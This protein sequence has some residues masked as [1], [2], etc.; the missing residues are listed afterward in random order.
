MLKVIVDSLD[1]VPESI[2]DEYVER[3][4]K[5]VLQLD[6]AFSTL[7]RDALQTALGK[8]RQETK[9][10]R[11]QLRKFGDLTPDS[12]E[13]LRAQ[14]EQLQLQL[15]TVNA[16]SDEERNKKIEELVERRAAA[17]VRPLERKLEQ[18]GGELQEIAGERDNLRRERTQNAVIGA[19]TDPALLKE[20]G[21]VPDA[22]EDIRVWATMNFEIEE[23]TDR[24]VSRDTLGTPGLAP[25]DVYADMRTQGQR[26]HWFGST[27][28]AGAS[29]GRDGN[30]FANNPFAEK[31]LNLTKIGE[32]VRSNPQMAIR[33][34][35]AVGGA[36]YLP[37][38]LREQAK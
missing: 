22:V 11:E 28:G 2:R 34:A 37:Q 38:S 36:R 25:K 30:N 31:T 20:F 8:E 3:D 7:D 5:F 17:R 35:K 4:G 10:A 27:Q 1:D 12:I 24:V 9:K 29:G 16:E 33:M 32:I 21:I 23:G 19:V 15:E 14:N 13:E 18:I 6:G 26:R